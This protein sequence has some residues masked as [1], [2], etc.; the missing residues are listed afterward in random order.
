MK[1]SKT[2]YEAQ[3]ADRFKKIIQPP[4]NRFPTDKIL[5]RLWRTNIFLRRYTEMYRNLLSK[6]FKSVVLERQEMMQCKCYSWHQTET[7][8]LENL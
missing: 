8:L 4:P 7:F 6:R 2:F 3:T 1:N 5:L